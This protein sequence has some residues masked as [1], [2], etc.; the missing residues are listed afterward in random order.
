MSQS[1]YIHDPSTGEPDPAFGLDLFGRIA[2]PQAQAFIC[3]E[4]E[5][6]SRQE[7]VGI[8]TTALDRYRTIGKILSNFLR[9]HDPALRRT[10]NP[11]I[12]GPH[13]PGRLPELSQL[14]AER[15]WRYVDKRGDDEC[16]PWLGGLSSS[17]YGYFKAARKNLRAHRVAYLLHFDKD[18][19][20]LLICHKCD[21]PICVNPH[22]AFLG[23][24][25]ENT[26]DRHGKGR[27]SG[28]R[29]FWKVPKPKLRDASELDKEEIAFIC[30]NY[31]PMGQW[32]ASALA[33][34]FVV[35]TTEIRKILL[36][37]KSSSRQITS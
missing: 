5:G 26:D 15:F 30:S 19:F 21:N 17:G 28:G 22:H 23:T 29:R 2:I 3:D 25:I 20:P 9:A 13:A 4:M 36:D 34:K 7:I 27:S 32:G 31:N 35:R 11:V 18:P 14:D 12:A 8:A 24:H 16:W 37:R 33:R 1:N 10:D 6:L